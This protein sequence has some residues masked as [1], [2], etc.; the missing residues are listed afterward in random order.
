MPLASPA[1]HDVVARRAPPR[2]LQHFDIGHAVFGEEALFLGDEQRRS[3]GQRDEAEGRSYSPPVPATFGD[4]HAERKLR[5]CCANESGSA[6]GRFQERAAADAAG[7]RWFLSVVIAS[8]VL[9]LASL[10]DSASC[11][12]PVSQQKSRSPRARSCSVSPGQ[13]RCLCGPSLDRSALV[14][15]GA[16]VSSLFYSSVVPTS[17]NS[18]ISAVISDAWLVLGESGIRQLRQRFDAAYEP[19]QAQ[20]LCSATSACSFQRRDR[21][22][23]R[24]GRR[25]RSASKAGPVNA[26]MPS[27][28]SPGGLAGSGSRALS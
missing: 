19:Q 14:A 11:V 21:P 2:L 24:G 13:R 7:L 20:N 3:I 5:L 17:D 28:G 23:R 16:P 9:S 10:V 25:C 6:R 18:G 22:G 4:V 1:Q 27:A 12:P 8:V 26:P 15:S